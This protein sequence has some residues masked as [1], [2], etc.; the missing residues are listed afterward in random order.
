MVIYNIIP[1]SI[2]PILNNIIIQVYLYK[3][4]GHGVHNNN[5]YRIIILG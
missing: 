2:L 1:V 3:V 5:L 4:P